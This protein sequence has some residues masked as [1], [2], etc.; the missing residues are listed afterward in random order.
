MGISENLV[1]RPPL[2][3]TVGWPA[4]RLSGELGSRQITALYAVITLF[5]RFTLHALGEAPH[6]NH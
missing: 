3:G 6:L 1:L 4:F 2:C 5:W